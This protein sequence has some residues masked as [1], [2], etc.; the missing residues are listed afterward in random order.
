MRA[1]QMYA[2]FAL[3]QLNVS[4]YKVGAVSHLRVFSPAYLLYLFVFHRRDVR[5]SWI[6]KWA[7]KIKGWEK[8]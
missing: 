7:K 2:L 6:E 5:N 3:R 4:G 1:G 8:T